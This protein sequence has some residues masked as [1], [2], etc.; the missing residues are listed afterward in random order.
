ME[1]HHHA[2]TPRKKW[3]HYFWEFLMLFLAVTLGFF[4]ENQREHYVEHQRAKEYAQLMYDDLKKDTLLLND[5]VKDIRNHVKSFDTVN[6]LFDQ[7]PPVSNQ[8]L[9]AAI[10]TQRTTYPWELIPTTF[11]QMKSS[12][13]LR[14]FKNK[15]LTATVSNYYDA[16]YAYLNKVFDYVNVFFTTDVQQFM[17]NHFDYSQSDYFTDKLKVDNPTYFDRS[18][19]ADLLLRNRMILYNS[20]LRYL[21]EDP[22]KRTIQKAIE[23]MELIKGEYHLK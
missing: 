2:H 5:V 10:L 1:V 11:N 6:T 13:S 20:L 15:E 16:Q 17:L 23:L 7:T 18:S 3:T 19:K 21:A 14:Y 8:R 4:V 22:I 12:G 9:I